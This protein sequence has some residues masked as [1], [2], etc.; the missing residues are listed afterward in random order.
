M[1]I[2]RLYKHVKESGL[3]MEKEGKK[4]LVITSLLEFMASDYNE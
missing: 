2:S 1:G 3:E 4:T